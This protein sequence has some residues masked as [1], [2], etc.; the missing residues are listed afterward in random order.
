MLGLEI[1]LVVI[2]RVRISF[3]F[4]LVTAGALAWVTL[5]AFFAAVLTTGLGDAFFAT[6]AALL[7]LVTAALGLVF[8][9]GVLLKKVSSQSQ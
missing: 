6:G 8:L 3:N 1:L 2:G 5:T 9:A 4:D 7:A